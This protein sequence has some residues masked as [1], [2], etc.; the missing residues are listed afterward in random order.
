MNLYFL[1]VN[2]AGCRFRS[3]CCVGWT[4]DASKV[5]G[6]VLLLTMLLYIT[7]VNRL[8]Y[9]DGQAAVVGL[10][11]EVNATDFDWAFDFSDVDGLGHVARNRHLLERILIGA[12]VFFDEHAQFTLYLVFS[13]YWHGAFL[14][15]VFINL[16]Q[17]ILGS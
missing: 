6:G 13:R 8:S 5:L 14:L 1:K 17:S 15:F 7:K 4:F 11:L 3:P 12:A 9:I 2:E 10:T 16:L